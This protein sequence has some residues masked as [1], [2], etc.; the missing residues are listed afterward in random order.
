MVC[1]VCLAT[2]LAHAQKTEPLVY[3]QNASIVCAQFDKKDNL[4]IT[5]SAN[6]IVKLWDPETGRF[7][8][9][10]GATQPLSNSFFADFSPD[11]K[12]VVAINGM[13]GKV[14]NTKYGDFIFPL[15]G[16]GDTIVSIHFSN[17]SKWLITASRDGTVER[18]ER[19]T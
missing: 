2:S 6:G 18:S 10:F 17:D 1:L 15:T 19:Q 8:R 7:I 12:V 16:Y 9:S 4:V 3:E 11:G 14:W 5:G 13:G